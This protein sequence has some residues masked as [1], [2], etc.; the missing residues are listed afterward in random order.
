MET[1]QTEAMTAKLAELRDFNRAQLANLAECGEPSHDT[2]G[3]AFLNEVRD[4]VCEL[5]EEIADELDDVDDFDRIDDNGALHEIADGAPSV[6]TARKWSQFVDLSAF[7]EDPSEFGDF[8]NMDKAGGVAL[9][10]I[11]DRLARALV[12]EVREAV[13]EAEEPDDETDEDGA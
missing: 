4:G 2:P 11:A 3:H 9:Y 10:M 13:D 6:Y 5:F 12:D 1:Y 8:E 7:W